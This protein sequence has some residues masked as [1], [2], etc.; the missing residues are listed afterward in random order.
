MEY[1]WNEWW[2][3][4]SFF[5]NKKKHR[6][7]DFCPCNKPRIKSYVIS[8]ITSKNCPSKG[9]SKK[10]ALHLTDMWYNIM[11]SMFPLFSQLPETSQRFHNSFCSLFI[12]RFL[13][14]YIQSTTFIRVRLFE[15]DFE[16]P[17]NINSLYILMWN[18]ACQ[19]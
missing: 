13:F 17:Y 19:K 7:F 14:S 4:K 9:S 18:V 6:V 2:F 3:L 11:A 12:T 1:S 10:I 5:E 15:A 8:K 16:L